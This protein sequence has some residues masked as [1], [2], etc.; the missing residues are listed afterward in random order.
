MPAKTPRDIVEKLNRET[1]KAL[2]STK[3]RERLSQLGVDT[4]VMTPAEL[5]VHVQNEIALNAAL[6]K[7]IGIKPE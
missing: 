3:L 4:M 6:V 2:H 5:D 1:L 7:A